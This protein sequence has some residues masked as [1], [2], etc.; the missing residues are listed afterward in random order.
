MRKSLSILS[1]F[2]LVLFISIQGCGSL[3]GVKGTEKLIETS[4]KKPKMVS[5]NIW[6]EERKDTKF[7]L[8]FSTESH[9]LDVALRV[10][11][12]EGR[13]HIIEG[14]GTDIRVEG[15]R[16]LSGP[17]KESVG[18]FFEEAMAWLTDNMRLSGAILQETYWEKW[19]RIGDVQ[20]SYFYKA[21]GIVRISKED[22]ARAMSAAVD[23]LIGKAAQDR[24]LAAERAARGAKQRLL[25]GTSR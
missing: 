9:D 12:L 15:T 21:Y 5:K 16:G 24:N 8:G 18:R 20:V 4:G 23:A 19:A 2:V 10:A 13:K 3:K 7:F 11:E 1:L 6:V 22:Y 25:E 14:I 17:E